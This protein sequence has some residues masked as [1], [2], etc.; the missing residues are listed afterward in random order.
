MP[1]S[2]TPAASPRLRR[3]VSS[4]KCA[5][6]L[7]ATQKAELHVRRTQTPHHLLNSTSVTPNG[8]HFVI[9]HSGDP[10]IDADRHR[11]VIHGLVRRPLVFTLDALMRYPMVSRM[12]LIECSRQ[13]RASWPAKIQI[14]VN[15]QHSTGLVSCAEWTGVMLSR[16][17]DEAGIDPKARS[18][19]WRERRLAG[20][21]RSVP[22]SKA[23]D[24]AMIALYRTVSG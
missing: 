21:D 15:V 11:L 23:L 2:C 6:T 17:F 22:V 13:R 14:D 1:L 19:S 12:A 24:D 7:A 5:R 18:R 16:F 3:A 9:S 10:D 4:K 8:L 20:A